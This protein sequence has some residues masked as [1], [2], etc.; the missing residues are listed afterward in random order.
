M[1]HETLETKADLS[2]ICIDLGLDQRQIPEIWQQKWA[3][4]QISDK[5]PELEILDSDYL[6]EM[7][8]FLQL[9][10][11]SLAALTQAAELVKSNAGLKALLLVNHVLLYH[12]DTE[13][14]GERFTMPEP[15]KAMANLAGLM[16]AL[17]ILSGLPEMAA[18]YQKQAIS[19]DI[20][21][22]TLSDVRI[23]MD[24]YNRK[25]GRYG[26]AQYWWLYGHFLGKLFR[27]GRLQYCYINFYGS[28]KAY[29][30]ITGRH[31]CALSVGGMT[32]RGDGQVDGTNGMFD[33]QNAWTSTLTEQDDRIQGYPVTPDGNAQRTPVVLM[34]DQWREVLAP[35]MGVLDVHIPEDG[36]LDHAACGESIKQALTFFQTHFPEKQIH[37]FVCLSWL[38]DPQLQQILDES[39]NI[40][41]FQRELYL[42]PIRSDDK[43]TFERVFHVVSPDIRQLNA[44]T[45]LQKAILRY[46][47]AGNRMH[48]AAMFLLADDIGSWGRQIYQSQ[49]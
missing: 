19:P 47:K 11:A 17:I 46:I 42:Y 49:L 13:Y 33:R 9:D 4:L 35:G 3:D 24:D 27:I 18:Y 15:Y 36:R 12:S 26:L 43:Q 21:R 16:P 39:A 41:R 8:E 20:L 30:Q 34:K 1:N 2:R 5:Q 48:A 44:T 37:A 28:V 22:S 40:S 7:N 23:W 32:Y 6:Q 14:G 38:L 45:N 29:R 10:A 31:V 25:N